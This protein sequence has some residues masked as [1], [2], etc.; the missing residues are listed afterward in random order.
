MWHKQ[1]LNSGAFVDCLLI[2]FFITCRYI[3]ILYYLNDVEDGRGIA[4][5]VADIKDLN[6][7]AS[8]REIEFL[9]LNRLD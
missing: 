4:F 2:R 7:T 3:T 1:L 8:V 6:E 9:R 5:S